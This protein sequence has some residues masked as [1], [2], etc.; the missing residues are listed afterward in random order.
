MAAEAGDLASE[1]IERERKTLLEILHQDPESVLDTLTS[2]RLISE[3]EYESLEKVT[4]PLKKS[5]KLLI[6][7]QK[8]GEGSCL[9]LLKCLV[10]TFPESAA[11][12]DLNLRHEFLKRETIEPSRS[13]EADKISEK[14]FHSVKKQPENVDITSSKE[15]GQLDLETSESLVDRSISGRGR[16]LSS[17][18]KG[19]DLPECTFTYSGED[20]EYGVSSAIAYLRDGQRY[21]EP[22]DSLYLGEEEYLRLVG[23][24]EHR[25]TG[26]EEE[27]CGEPEHIIYDGEDSPEYSEATDFSDDGQSCEESDTGMP[28]EEEEEESMEERKKVFRNVL[29]CLNMDRNRKLLPDSVEQFSADRGT[30]WV[31]ETP[32]DLV[33][34]FL[35]KVRAQDV[36]ARDAI[37]RR[38]VLSEDSKGELLTEMENLQLRDIQTINHLDVLCATMLC[39]DS[40]LRCEVMSNMYQCQFALPLLLPDAEN[41]RS[42]LML[43]SMKN[44]V[45]KQSGPPSEGPAKAA[46]TLL[47]HIKMPVISF[48]RFQSCG[49]S[50]SRILNTLLRP[51]LVESC[52]IFLHQA[53]SPLMLPRQ[54][55]DGLVEIT[56]CFPDGDSLTENDLF[57]QK[58]VAVTNLRGD[59]ER[60]WT[61]FGFLMEV[62]SAVFFFADNLGEQE[63]TLL[64]FLGEAALERC[65]FVLSSK[66]RESE[67]AHV[68]QRI[69][70]L[71]PSQI[72]FLEG[73]EA[74]DRE[75]GIA[76]LQAVLQEVLCSS[77]SSVSLED[78]AYLARELG[79][80]VDQDCEESQGIQVSAGENVARLAESE[81]Q[82]RQNQ[83]NPPEK[84]SAGEPGVMCSISQ[85]PQNIYPTPVSIPPSQVSSPLQA[86]M[87]GGFNQAF[88]KPAWLMGPHFWSEQRCRWFRPFAFH[89]TRAYSRGKR[90][91]PSYFQPPRFHSSE[92]FMNFP[93]PA[94]G[95]GWNGTIGMQ[96]RLV[97]PQARAWPGTPKTVGAFGKPGTVVSRSGP[98]HSLGSQ[99]AGGLGRSQPGLVCAQGP[100]ATGRLLRTPSHTRDPHCQGFHPKAAIQKL[101]KP[102]PQLG[103]QTK[104]Q[105]GSSNPAFQAQ[106]PMTKLLSSSQFKSN[107][108]K[109][110]QPKFSQPVLSQ[111]KPTQLEATQPQPSHFKGS[112][113]TS[114][115]PKPQFHS[116]QSKPTQ[117]QPFHSKGPQSKP[118]QPSP[119][120]SHAHQPKPAHPSPSQPHTHQPKPTHPS[121]SQP[122]AHQPKH[123]QPSPS[124]P[125]AH[126][127]KTQSHG[128]Q[129]KPTQPKPSQPC[130]HQAKS[131]QPKYFQAKSS[132][133][134]PSQPKS[135]RASS[136]QTRV[137][138]SRAGSRR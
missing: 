65:Y 79:I 14:N 51:S 98:F 52:P 17:G 59:L 129:Y 87:R 60:F 39:S 104:T 117:P 73:E 75:K 74:G 48:V 118:A 35:V 88:W 96:P 135:S 134:R 56:W 3:E 11:V 108:T 78:M 97:S 19:S 15:K 94:Q 80:Q 42:I 90:F 6:L 68:F 37:V 55:S 124:Q 109:H 54:I 8:K 10:T 16:T 63:W 33:W 23:Y 12:W 26:M 99:Q 49:F 5:R 131:T 114:T 13:L 69:L 110:S 30:M 102:A 24:L 107:Q 111:A 4:D 71:K 122:H 9:H 41:N 46:E 125:H 20:V 31:P 119:S 101:I 82:Q 136:S 28:L 47:T 45:K 115:Q 67:E 18:E 34:D 77:F 113:S 123:P 132:Q 7:I 50:K 61:Q 83:Q 138:Y 112:P 116:H 58:P 137:S 89:N 22:D 128:H 100:T 120:Q 105:S 91:G 126:Q 32:G 21:M 85:N 103:A 93:R 40:S 81:D 64:R 29:S 44:V 86:R 76:C 95:C 38:R 27:D 121:P 43:G 66:A 62:S 72:V 53:S 25:E 1:I 127:P 92:R 84:M 36:T 130:T 2:R 133:S 70:Q 106:H 57:V